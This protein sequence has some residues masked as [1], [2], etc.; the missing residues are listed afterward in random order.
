M[1]IH[2]PTIHPGG[3]AQQD[4]NTRQLVDAINRGIMGARGPE[5]KIPGVIFPRMYAFCS[6]YCAL[7]I[8]TKIIE[9]W[10]DGL[11]AKWPNASRF[12]VFV[13]FSSASTTLRFQAT[14]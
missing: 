4:N 1:S 13:Y 11:H 6:V 3:D 14:T 10:A 8:P 2:R 9:W 5:P 12:F 7:C